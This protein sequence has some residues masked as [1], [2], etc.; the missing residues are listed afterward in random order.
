MLGSRAWRLFDLAVAL[1]AYGYFFLHLGYPWRLAT[2]LGFAFGVLAFASR[3]T[4]TNLARLYSGG[5]SWVRLE[6]DE[7][8]A[9]EAPAESPLDD[10]LPGDE[11]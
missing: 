9:G 3:R 8:A 11:P 4:F 7:L 10:E 1:T 5:P 2:V 6:D